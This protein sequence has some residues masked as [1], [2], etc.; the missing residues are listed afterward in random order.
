MS[1]ALDMAVVRKNHPLLRSM[2]EYQ[3][4][5]SR[6]LFQELALRLGVTV[7]HKSLFPTSSR[8][9][10]SAGRFFTIRLLALSAVVTWPIVEYYLAGTRQVSLVQMLAAKKHFLDLTPR[11]SDV[12]PFVESHWVSLGP[13]TIAELPDERGECLRSTPFLFWTGYAVGGQARVSHRLDRM[14]L[15]GHVPRGTLFL[16]RLGE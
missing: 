14:P 15:V 3:I 13:G 10:L 11:Q 5:I 9:S 7:S 1:A 6:E 16:I 2:G 4:P 8:F 12:L